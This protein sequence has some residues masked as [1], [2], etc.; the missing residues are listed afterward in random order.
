[1]ANKRSNFAMIG[2]RNFIYVYG[3]IS[4]AGQGEESHHPQLA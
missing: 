1:M 3:G 4:G 2:L